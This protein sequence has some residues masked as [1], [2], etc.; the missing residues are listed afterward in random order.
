MTDASAHW[1]ETYAE[2][3]VEELSWTEAVPV[4][5]LALVQEAAL[6]LDAAIIDVGG[7]ASRLTSELLRLG[8]GDVTVADISTEAL[9]RA[10][11]DLGKGG[12][13]GDM[14]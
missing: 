10:K 5:S 8:Y 4:N 6:P 9:G 14:G 7:G 13:P 1:Q 2:R 12:G 3:S 11:A